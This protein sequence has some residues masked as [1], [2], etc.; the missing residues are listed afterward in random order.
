MEGLLGCRARWSAFNEPLGL[1][2][3]VE[4][5]VNSRIES[6]HDAVSLAG[7]ASSFIGDLLG[8]EIRID[9]KPSWEFVGSSFNLYSFRAYCPQSTHGVLRVVEYGGYALNISGALPGACAERSLPRERGF[10]LEDVR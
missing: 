10:N 5:T 8:V 3:S 4:C 7:D 6:F 2:V 9:A 1:P